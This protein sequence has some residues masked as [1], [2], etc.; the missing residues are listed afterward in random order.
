MF[1]E[2]AVTSTSTIVFVAPDDALSV[3][4]DMIHDD[5]DVQQLK[6]IGAQEIAIWRT[7][8]DEVYVDGENSFANLLCQG[9]LKF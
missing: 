8:E 1:Y 4:I 9:N 5:L 3:I 2:A 7:P 6:G